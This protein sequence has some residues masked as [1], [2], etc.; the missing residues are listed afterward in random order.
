M[1]NA[2]LLT[3]LLAFAGG[4][5][6]ARSASPAQDPGA[7]E[8]V[9]AARPGPNHDRLEPL[10][11]RWKFDVTS[12][13]GPGAEPG[14]FELDVDYRWL[15]GGRFVIGTYEGFI[16]GEYYEARDVIGYD[17][18]AGEYIEAWFDNRTTAYTPGTG[19]F[20]AAGRTLTITGEEPPSQHGQAATPYRLVY[21]FHDEDRLTIEMH[22]TAEDGTTFRS[23]V[24]EGTRP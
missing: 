4:I 18:V 15:L 12:W 1:I 3:I 22:R 24:V 7:G 11:G 17:N 21:T 16:G 13:D 6:V 9:D 10:A 14:T 19:Q 23:F 20:D 2:R 8:A 5:V